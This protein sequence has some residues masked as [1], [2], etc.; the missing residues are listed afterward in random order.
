MKARHHGF[1]LIE[2]MLAL[3][4]GVLVVVAIVQLFV[5]NSAS[6][7]LLMG[8]A[9]LQ[10]NGRIALEMVGRSVRNAGFYGCAP[11]RQNI[12]MGLNGTDDMIF[13][14][15]ILR[16]VQ[17]IQ[18]GTG[19]TWY[20]GIAGNGGIPD[21]A[22]VAGDV[23][24]LR[25]LGNPQVRLAQTMQPDEDPAVPSVNGQAPFAEN[26]IVMLADC[27]QGAM[28][29]VTGV[30]NT[31]GNFSIQHAP[32]TSGQIFENSPATSVLAPTGL[33]YGRDALLAP[34]L[35]TFLYVAPSS[36]VVNNTGNVP[37]ALWMKEGPRAPVELIAG[38]E[39]LQVRFGIDDAPD[40]GVVR[41][42]RYVPYATVLA[43]GLSPR[44][45]VSVKASVRVNSTDVV[46]ETGDGLL[47]RTF[48]ETFFLRNAKPGS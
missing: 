34:V 20:D 48:T 22:I 7:S 38:V 42:S 44:Q 25:S 23:L 19:I 13:E 17:T 32:G 5:S 16:P 41:A 37:A 28:F 26:Q 30:A 45:I 24:V 21:A 47:R 43:E 40:D 4:L 36:V 11:E 6:Y 18:G 8:Q 35:T 15:D 39:N 12:L 14:F 31:G 1:S 33:S 10:E 46:T 2:L 9:R 3:A 27:D 29:R